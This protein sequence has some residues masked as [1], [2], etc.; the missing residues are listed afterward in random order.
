MGKR[1]GSG[2]SKPAPSRPWRPPPATRQPPRGSTGYGTTTLPARTAPQPAPAPVQAAPVAPAPSQ[3]PGLFGQM[4]ATAGG[5]AIGSAIGHTVGHAVTGM[6]GGGSS[7]A[8]AV[9]Q[10]AQPAAP[11]QQYG[12]QQ[13]DQEGPCGWE[14][15]QFLQCASQ[16]SDLTLCDGFNEALRQCKIRNNMVA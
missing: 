3:G 8:A 9:P 1:S 6:F 2:L 14:V 5:V 13:Q 10:Q 7:E 15:K 4:A 12:Q 16:Q 11:Q